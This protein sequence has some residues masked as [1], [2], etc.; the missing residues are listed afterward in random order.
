MKQ[1]LV[2]DRLYDIIN[3]M[4]VLISFIIVD[5]VHIKVK[6]E[7]L[8]MAAFRRMVKIIFDIARE[9]TSGKAAKVLCGLALTCIIVLCIALLLYI[10]HAAFTHANFISEFFLFAGAVMLDI[11]LLF[12][13]HYANT[14]Y[15]SWINHHKI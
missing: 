10:L 15:I 3:F 14:H 13:C 4:L 12:G 9:L 11:V 2:D 1:I 6:E 5:I 7:E 8:V